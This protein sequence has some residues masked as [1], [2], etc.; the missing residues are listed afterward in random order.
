[1]RWRSLTFCTLLA[2]LLAAHADAADESEP[3]RRF[4]VTF[5]A[6]SHLREGGDTEVISFGYTL[7]E[8]LT[9]LVSV[10]RNHVPTRVERHANGYSASRGGTVTLISGELRYTFAEASKISP[11]VFA[12][13]GAGRSRPNVNDIFPESVT[14]LARGAYA[15]G[16]VLVS[17]TPALALSVEAK[18]QLMVERDSVGLL[19]PIRAGVTWRF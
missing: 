1:M 7:P 16:G 18:S 6:G 15:G 10:E 17:V 8:A 3:P 2:L 14:N 4:S 12:G 5:G 19:L 11:F 13:A 9:V